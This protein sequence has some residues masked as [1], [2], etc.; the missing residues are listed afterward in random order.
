MTDNLNIQFDSSTKDEILGTILGVDITKPIKRKEVRKLV[1]I[2]NLMINEVAQKEGISIH[3][4][5]LDVDDEINA[6]TKDWH[7]DDLA[8]FMNLQADELF[9]SA[10]EMN[11]QADELNIQTMEKIDQ[12]SEDEMYMK[13]VIGIIGLIIFTIIML[14]IFK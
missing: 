8:T 14:L 12:A 9:A 1:R 13:V 11:Q 5:T 4:A 6:V 2:R 7:E 10:A 3:H